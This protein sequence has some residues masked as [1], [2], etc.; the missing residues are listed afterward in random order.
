VRVQQLVEA[1][2]E[3]DA[4]AGDDE[5]SPLVCRVRA[6]LAVKFV[7]LSD[8][9][10][11]DNVEQRVCQE[12]DNPNNNAAARVIDGR[13]EE[14]QHDLGDQSDMLDNAESD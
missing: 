8:H 7:L 14:A 6:P 13:V 9:L 2:V 10:L 5:A 1:P 12:V 11:E 3:H 4:A